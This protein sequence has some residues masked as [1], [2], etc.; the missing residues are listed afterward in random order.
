[1]TRNQFKVWFQ[2]VRRLRNNFGT[3]IPRILGERDGV[4]FRV[5]YSLVNGLT[6][7][8]KLNNRD[9]YFNRMNDMKRAK[10]KCYKRLALQ[11]IRFTR[12]KPFAGQSIHIL[13]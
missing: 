1:M 3:D 2:A 7:T 9:D 5:G 8:N 12:M 10:G 6:R 11:E 4:Q 13:P